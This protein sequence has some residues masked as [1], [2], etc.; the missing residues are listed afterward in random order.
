VLGLTADFPELALAWASVAERSL[1]DAA[2]PGLLA[3]A[4]PPVSDELMAQWRKRGSPSAID[5]HQRA[6]GDPEDPPGR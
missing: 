6:A 4:E 2:M 5:D 1:L 3:G